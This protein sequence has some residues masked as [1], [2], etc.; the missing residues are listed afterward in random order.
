MF[1]ASGGSP[2]F[3]AC[4]SAGAI[5][6]AARPMVAPQTDMDLIIAYL[7]PPMFSRT[8]PHGGAFW[9]VKFS[10]SG[11]AVKARKPRLPAAFCCGRRHDGGQTVAP[12]GAAGLRLAV[13][14]E[15]A[16]L[17]AIPV[18]VMKIR[19]PPRETVMILV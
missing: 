16:N 17:D 12:D 2:T 6:S 11:S 1:L 19:V 14:V 3:G 4:A 15:V 5:A 7:L 8:V 9:R 18:G 10:C 13:L